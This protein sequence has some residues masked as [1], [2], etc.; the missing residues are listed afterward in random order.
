MA[1]SKHLANTTDRLAGFLDA[2]TE[3]GISPDPA[4]IVYAD[5]RQDRARELCHLLL[6]GSDRPTALFVSNNQMT[7][8]ALEAMA[9]LELSCPRDVSLASIDDFPWAGTF[10]PR[11]T[12]Q[13][14][15]IEALADHA[16]RILHA[17]MQG[18]HEAGIERV[19]LASE[20]IIR[21]SC[22]PPS[23]EQID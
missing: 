1:G 2:M 12:T 16:V 4:H 11:L 9:D 3:A 20:L 18:D 21:N 15:P 22:A 17:R 6:S 19:V 23:R 13:R 10:A 5:F 14:Q 7:I 8:G